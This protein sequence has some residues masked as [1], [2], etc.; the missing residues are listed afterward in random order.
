M[1]LV[2]TGH[3]RS[4]TTRTPGRKLGVEEEL[5]LVDPD[6]RRLTALAEH[7]VR[8][9]EAAPS[10]EAPV[11]R[12]LFLQQ[13][14]TQTPPTADPAELAEGLRAGRRALVE[15][16]EAAGARAVAV[17]TPVLVDDDL[18]FTRKDRYLRIREEY[19]ELAR[20]SLASALHVHVDVDDDEEGVRVLDGIAPWLPL[21]LAASASSP[22]SHGRDTGHA[23]WR[24]QQWGRWPS[25]GTGEPFG[26]VRTY[27]E[28]TERQVDW[29]AALDQ[30][31]TYFDARLAQDYPTVEIRVADV[32]TD[33]DDALL[34]AVLCRALVET[35][36]REEPVR[37][38]SELL[39]AATWR[40]SRDGLGG[41]LVGPSSQRLV[42]PR[43]ALGELLDH[44]RPALHDAGD[45][46]LVESHLERL[47]ARGSSATQQ[48]RT[49]ESSGSL[50]AVVDDLVERT[51][52]S[53]R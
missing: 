14:E 44:V 19:G 51:A 45:V 11:E 50:E 48:R 1:V 12:E 27:R 30:G 24:A 25:H 46:E 18:D 34:V 20:S 2:S 37:W 10:T 53:V 9:G 49:W 52:A 5:L 15:A 4:V 35:A 40:A 3:P 33:L 38:R 28:V 21:L 7:A 6:T 13:V 31:M 26:D 23:S 17:G 43:D 42:T 29:G 32:C 39:R 47:L 41:R 8:A 36:A 22:Y 16:A